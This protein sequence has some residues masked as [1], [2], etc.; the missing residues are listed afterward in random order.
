MNRRDLLK[1]LPLAAIVGTTVKLG[2]T[3]AQAFEM[4]SDKKYLFVL[5]SA[6]PEEAGRYAEILRKRGINATVATGDFEM[7]IY[8]IG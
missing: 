4:K 6:R 3:E 1:V 8:E 5:P 2:E 7:K